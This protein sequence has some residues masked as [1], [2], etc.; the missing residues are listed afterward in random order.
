MC[1]CVCVCV[2]GNKLWK[3]IRQCKEKLINKVIHS[4]GFNMKESRRYNVS[5]ST[6]HHQDVKNTLWSVVG[7]MID[8]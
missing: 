1:V 8:V 2:C 4:E 7:S 3:R 5:V 6:N